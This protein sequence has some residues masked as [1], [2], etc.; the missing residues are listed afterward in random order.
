ML[1]CFLQAHPV[2]KM[3]IFYQQFKEEMGLYTIASYLNY[4][5][6]CL[7]QELEAKKGIWV[8][9]YQQ[10]RCAVFHLH[11]RIAVAEALHYPIASPSTCTKATMHNL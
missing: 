2:A 7:A 10:E 3:S 6:D 5:Q 8:K 1:T 11:D 4:A 9:F